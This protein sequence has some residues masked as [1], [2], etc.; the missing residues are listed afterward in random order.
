LHDDDESSAQIEMRHEAVLDGDRDVV[1]VDLQAPIRR[2]IDLVRDISETCPH[3]VI[4][5]RVRL[6][7]RTS[8]SFQLAIHD[9]AL[10]LSPKRLASPPVAPAATR[11][12]GTAS[13][14]SAR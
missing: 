5:A 1:V 9:G 6:R 4:I 2:G 8:V 12:N 14:V 7:S 10:R 3:A 11:S 13:T